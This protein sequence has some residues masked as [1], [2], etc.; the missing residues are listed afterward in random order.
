MQTNTTPG[1]SSIG[2]TEMVNSESALT[3]FEV[4]TFPSGFYFDGLAATVQ[5]GSA[6]VPVAQVLSGTNVTLVWESSVVDTDAFTIY[7]SSASHGQWTRTPENLGFWESPPLT[8]DTVFT[9]AVTVDIEG[10]QPLTAS[11]T[12]V[13]SVQNPVLIAADVSTTGLAVSGI[14]TLADLFASGTLTAFGDSIL[15]TAVVSETLKVLGASTF[16]GISAQNV[17]ASGNI[18]AQG[19]VKSNGLITSNIR[20]AE[21]QSYITSAN[22]AG[23]F[24]NNG[25]ICTLKTNNS[26]SDT[27]VTTGIYAEV[28]TNAEWGI[29]S[30]GTIGTSNGSSIVTHLPTSI[31]HRVVTSPLALYSEVQFSGQGRVEQG[32]ATVTFESGVA[33]L[34][35]KSTSYRVQITPIGKWKALYVVSK[36]DHGFEVAENNG[37]NSSG[38]FD[39]FVVARKAKGLGEQDPH[40][41]PE[42]MPTAPAS[43]DPKF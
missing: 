8:S 39:W 25:G 5:S 10:G 27:S 9:V 1:T 17:R 3:S 7:Y 12:T 13:V 26:T 21:I 6:L 31:G 16:A 11:L 35:A 43:E 32:R 40:E 30:N 42:R 24:Y 20:A 15:R 4:T 38:E 37:D 23:L 28:E 19:V 41:L 29:G 14:T 18:V 33:D 2:V 36:N 22:I 34:I